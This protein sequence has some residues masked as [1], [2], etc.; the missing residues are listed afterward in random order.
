MAV[1][2]PDRAT[3]AQGGDNI[4]F[5]SFMKRIRAGDEQAAMDLVVRY[6]PAIRRAVRVR[7][8]DQRLRRLV[9]SVDICQ[10]V[11]ASFFVRTSLGQYDLE[12]PDQL[13]RLLAAIARNKV[14]EQANREHAARRDQR[15]NCTGTILV[16]HPAPGDSPSRQ[17]AALELAQEARRRMTVAEL[18][19]LDRR[20]QGLEWAEIA[21][22]LGGRP[23]TL[24]IRFA[25]AV[26]RITRELGLDEGRDE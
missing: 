1:D 17:L 15:R 2:C 24:R 7:L 23:D 25:R 26:T 13:I 22:E 18:Q 9:E 5:A 12:S 20:E 21:K 6:E 11:F 14:A 10:S 16:D 3:P 4:S 19:L 8:R